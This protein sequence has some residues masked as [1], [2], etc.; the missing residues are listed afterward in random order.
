MMLRLM[1]KKGTILPLCVHSVLHLEGNKIQVPAVGM[2][3]VVT[4]AW[5]LDPGVTGYTMSLSYVYPLH[6]V[7]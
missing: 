7:S 4:R 2:Y 6:V 3:L 5:Q 1:S